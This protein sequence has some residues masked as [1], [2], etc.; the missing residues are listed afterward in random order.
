MRSSNFK[1]FYCQF[2]LNLPNKS[3]FKFKIQINNYQVNIGIIYIL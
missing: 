1:Y 3:V 2:D